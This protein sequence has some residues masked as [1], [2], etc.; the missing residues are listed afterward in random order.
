MVAVHLTC[1]ITLILRPILKALLGILPYL[2]L[3]LCYSLR[4]EHDGNFWGFSFRRF[5]A[6]ETDVKLDRRRKDFAF[7][8]V[9]VTQMKPTLN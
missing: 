4:A 9:G 3:S 2:A 7:H 8:F 5:H 6:D 1:A